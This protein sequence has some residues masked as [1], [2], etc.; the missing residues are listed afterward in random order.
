MNV[1]MSCPSSIR[2]RDLNPRPL[3]RESTPITTRPGLLC[4]KTKVKSLKLTITFKMV[5]FYFLD[6]RPKNF[7]TLTTNSNNQQNYLLFDVPND[8]SSILACGDALCLVSCDFDVHNLFKLSRNVS[9]V[10]LKVLMLLFK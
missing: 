5:H 1:K 9:H 10:L 4:S 8:A 7:T 3:E 6:F 2:R